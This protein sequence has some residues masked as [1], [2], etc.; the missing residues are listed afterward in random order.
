MNALSDGIMVIIILLVS[1]VVLYISIMCIR[2]IVLTRLEKDRRE[3]GM[4]KAVGISRMDIRKLYLS[5][6]LLL[7]AIGCLVGSV[8]ACVI[9][10]PLG[11]GMRELYGEADDPVL[12]YAVMIAG[13]VFAPAFAA[14]PATALPAFF[15][16]R[17]PNPKSTAE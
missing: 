1:L 5:K 8:S 11:K 6:Y 15:A 2:Y 17:E 12:V 16:F 13:A 10:L 7:S 3:I 9:A 14:W 4:L